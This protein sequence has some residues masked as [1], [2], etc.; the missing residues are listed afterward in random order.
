MRNPIAAPR[1]IP[2]EPWL[3]DLVSV[4]TPILPYV[5]TALYWRSQKFFWLEPEDARLARHALAKM[6]ADLLMGCKD[7]LLYE[8]RRLYR[9]LEGVYYGTSYTDT[10][11]LDSNG[12][13]L[14]TPALP[15]VPPEVPIAPSMLTHAS[16]ARNF[17]ASLAVA[18]TNDD[19][20]DA[21]NIRD[22]L[23]SIITALSEGENLDP[24][25][26][27]QLIQIAA[28]LV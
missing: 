13:P 10:G 23:D 21:R 8:H 20:T 25:M 14:V 27:E 11:E 7:E 18:E 4:D 16:A 17:L 3:C 26:L 6:G 12:L 5:L 15:S 24:Q 28:L 22:Q 1:S 19:A 9:L 2:D